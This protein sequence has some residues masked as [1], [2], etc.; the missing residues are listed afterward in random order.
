MEK[1]DIE[2]LERKI[3]ELH[4]SLTALRDQDPV[5][6]VITIIH[7]PGW[8]SVAEQAFFTGIVDAMLMQTKTLSALKQVLLSGAT[9]VE[10]NPQ[11]LPP[12]GS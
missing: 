8:T 4:K 11:P 12:L 1:H 7:K 5:T 3:H 9:N 10:L 2:H 6:G